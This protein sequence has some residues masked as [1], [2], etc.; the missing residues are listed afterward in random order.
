MGPGFDEYFGNHVGQRFPLFR[1]PPPSG[2]A[3]RTRHSL[4]GG[5]QES[6]EPAKFRDSCLVMLDLFSRPQAALLLLVHCTKIMAHLPAVQVCHMPRNLLKV[7]YVLGA[8]L[9]LHRTLAAFRAMALRRLELS[10]LA[11]A[12]P[13]FLPPKRPSATAA[14]FFSGLMASAPVRW[15]TV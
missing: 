4:I 9:R 11:R 7:R 10:F 1:W 8:C 12:G 3:V 14:G 13:P 6:Q 2:G 5:V 15:A